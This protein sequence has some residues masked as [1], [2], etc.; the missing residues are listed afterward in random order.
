MP[1]RRLDP[2][3]IDDLTDSVEERISEKVKSDFKSEFEDVRAEFISQIASMKSDMIAEIVS[4][5][6]GVPR[7]VGT[8]DGYEEVAGDF[9]TTISSGK[10]KQ[11]ERPRGNKV[12]QLDRSG[13]QLKLKH[14]ME[15][16]NF[17]G[18]LNPED[19]ID[20]IGELE[21]YFELEDI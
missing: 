7:H 14:K 20:W 10:A 9:E 21:D 19:L 8:E 3:E 16:S 4:A 6:G 11:D 12:V 15:V 1:P 5:L 18:T 2:R 17:S 13:S